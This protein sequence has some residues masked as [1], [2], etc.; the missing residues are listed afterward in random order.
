MIND[1]PRG[2]LVM[3]GRMER[4]NIYSALAGL[5]VTLRDRTLASER[6][7]GG[8]KMG[9]VWVRNLL[10]PFS[11]DRVK[12]AAPPSFFKGGNLLCP[13]H[14]SMAKFQVLR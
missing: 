11:Q 1:P 14:F 7:G 3:D 12:L 9:K 2:S 4:S 10:H 5:Y 6:G 8:Y 13:L